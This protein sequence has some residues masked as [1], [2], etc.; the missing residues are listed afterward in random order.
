ML[1]HLW[2]AVHHPAA[3]GLYA[4]YVLAGWDDIVE[5]GVYSVPYAAETRISMVD[6][7]DVA[8]AAATVLTEP[9]PRRRHL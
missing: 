9:E 7:R 8:E 1:F 2:P 6:L 5:R 3:R 4:E